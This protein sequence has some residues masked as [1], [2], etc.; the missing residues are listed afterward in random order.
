MIHQAIDFLSKCIAKTHSA[1]SQL[2]RCNNQISRP[3]TVGLLLS[4]F[5]RGFYNVAF[6]TNIKVISK[7][8]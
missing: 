5:F 7:N 2:V 6:D 1:K 8:F 3:K 4:R